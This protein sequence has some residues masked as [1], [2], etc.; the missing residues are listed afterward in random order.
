MTPQFSDTTSSFFDFAVFL[1]S[2]LVIGLN[3]MQYHDKFWS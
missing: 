2:S 1:L 3:I